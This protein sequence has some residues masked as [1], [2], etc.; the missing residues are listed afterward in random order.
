MIP[1]RNISVVSN[2]LFKEH[3]GRRIP[4]QV[5]ELDYCP[6]WFL[7]GLAGHP[8]NSTLAFKGGTCLRRCYFGEYRFSE[9]LDFT[10]T[11]PIEFSAI[12]LGLQEIFS[13]LKVRSGISMAYKEA[14]RNPH[15]N[16]HTFTLSYIGPFAKQRDVKVDVTINERVILQ[17]D[18]QDTEARVRVM[19]GHP[20]DESSEIFSV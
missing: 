13:D 15:Q 19:K 6:A 14:D 16:S 17:L 11:A 20:F 10:L 4:D 3:G 1:S 2:R 7:V 12:R 18:P 5:I 9:D 8:L